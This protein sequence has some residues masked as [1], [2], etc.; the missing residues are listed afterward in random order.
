MTITIEKDYDAMSLRAAKQVTELVKS[1]IP[2]I[3]FEIVTR[4]NKIYI[5][6]TST[7]MWKVD[8]PIAAA[9]VLNLDT[10]AGWGGRLSMVD[11]NS[12]ELFQSD[13]VTDIY[14]YRGR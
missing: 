13:M 3:H 10:G 2:D 5:G 14:G 6:H 1:K 8:Q 11:I 12:G 7:I 9:N 4:F